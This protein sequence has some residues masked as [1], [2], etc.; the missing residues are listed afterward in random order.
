MNR[1][2]VLALV[3]FVALGAG[4]GVAVTQQEGIKYSSG[5]GSVPPG[6]R[7]EALETFQAEYGHVEE[8]YGEASTSLGEWAEAE[9]GRTSGETIDSSTAGQPVYALFVTGNL[10]VDGP[11]LPEGGQARSTFVAGRIIFDASGDLVSI[12]LWP[13]E[14][15]ADP[16]FGPRFDDI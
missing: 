16:P 4:I 5:P 15:A 3:G 8:V 9:P 12:S 14:R 13:D 7:A 11:P 6:L 2:V 10:V 1:Y